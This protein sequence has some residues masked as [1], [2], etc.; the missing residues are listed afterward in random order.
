[1]KIIL[2]LALTSFSFSGLKNRNASNLHILA[3]TI[4]G[5]AQKIDLNS[6]DYIRVVDGLIA[7]DSLYF[8]SLKINSYR[9]ISDPE[10]LHELGLKEEVKPFLF[11]CSNPSE[12][13]EILNKKAGIPYWKQQFMIPIILD[14]ELLTPNKYYK[15]DELNTPNVLTVVYY[16]NDTVWNDRIKMP[17]GA[18]KVTTK[19]KN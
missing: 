17:L 11:I 15:I 16:P 19:S 18:I 3:D 4:P 6:N 7:S 14:D 10:R 8:N 12:N 9:K 5:Y 2:L 13:R 1:M